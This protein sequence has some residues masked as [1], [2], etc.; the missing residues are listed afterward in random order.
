[1]IA[2]VNEGR[3]ID[4]LSRERLDNHL[5]RLHKANITERLLVRNSETVFVAP[6]EYYHTISE[7]YFSENQLYIF[8]PKL[9]LL[10]RAPAAKIIVIND[11]RF[12]DCVRKLFNY[13]WERTSRPITQKA[14]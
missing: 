13:V 12:T 10:T 6:I 14:S 3:T 1:M 4:H 11:E 8:G 5:E 7:E 2:N 9:A